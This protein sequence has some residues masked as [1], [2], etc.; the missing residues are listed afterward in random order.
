MNHQHG[1]FASIK[2]VAMK[3]I[4]QLLASCVP[5]PQEKALSAFIEISGGGKHIGR[6]AGPLRTAPKQ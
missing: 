1:G 4:Q 3:G 2:K 6:I 5:S